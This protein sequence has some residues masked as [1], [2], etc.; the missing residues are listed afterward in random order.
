MNL[1]YDL[2]TAPSSRHPQEQM[3]ALGIAYEH[4]TPQS[5]GDQWWFWN[6]TGVPEALPEYLTLLALDPH[7][8][9]GYGLSTADAD[10]I[11]RHPSTR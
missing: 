7:E 8:C 2:Y 5:L 4:A 9:I 6:C 3:R 10:R 1:R 11:A